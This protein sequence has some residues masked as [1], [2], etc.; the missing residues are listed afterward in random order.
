MPGSAAGHFFLGRSYLSLGALG[1]AVRCLRR[2]VVCNP[3]LA[4]AWGLLGLAYAK[5][6]RFERSVDAFAKA[7]QIDPSN[8]R[9]VTGYL[10]ASLV[11]AIRL[12]YPGR[13]V[14]AGRVFHEVLRHRET[15]ILPH[16]YLCSIYRELGRENLAL[17]HMESASRLSPDD[18]FLHLQKALILLARGEPAQA[19]EEIRT[20]SRLLAQGAGPAGKPEEVLRFL[21]V[22]L[23]RQKRYREAVFYASKLLRASYDDAPLHALVAECYKSLGD[24][25]KARNHYERALDSDKGSREL[26][27]GLLAVLWQKGD[28]AETAEEASRLL[29]K[30]PHDEVGRYFESLALS[31]AGGPIEEVLARLQ[32]Q[33]K[34]RG[35]DPLL[36]AEL[37]AAY[38]RAGLPDLAEGWLVRTLRVQEDDPSVL[39]T[40]ARAYESLGRR[41]QEADVWKRLLGVRPDDRGARRRL[42]RLL[43][44]EGAFADA[45]QQ[46][47]RLLAFEPGSTRLKS[48]LAL[49]HRRSGRYGDALVILR[50]LLRDAP[51]S[52]EHAK[53]VVYCLDRMGSRQ[54]AIAF[55]EGFMKER[56]ESLSLVLIL[57]VLHYQAGDL[58]AS[59]TAFRRAIAAAPK[60]GAHTGTSAWCTARPATLS[61]PR[62]SWP[63]QRCTGRRPRA[64]KPRPRR[65]RL[66]KRRAEASGPVRARKKGRP[67]GRPCSSGSGPSR[68]PF[69][70]SIMMCAMASFDRGTWYG[71]QDT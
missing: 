40:L 33:I 19:L 27:L 60:A 65:P 24:L 20:G 32:G 47:A 28:Y 56:G 41:A 14:D 39:E 54:T 2:A 10:N 35:P 38:L 4:P 1:S 69:A 49:C 17:S 63:G 59:A 8:P 18:P 62:S 34:A 67:R 71:E 37:G 68:Q 48:L 46:T 22:N 26:R 5:G 31:R 11:Y 7:L 13:F 45:A 53:A 61:L 42:L 58:G 50:E 57:G 12:F 15:S 29:G 51:G 16:L 23:F 6:R 64:P 43:L 3:G 44:A 55:L 52:Q 30:D 21:A 36:M 25:S 9:M 70:L 66:P